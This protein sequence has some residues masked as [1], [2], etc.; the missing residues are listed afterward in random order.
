MLLDNGHGICENTNNDSNLVDARL[1]IL[2]GEL[3]I[4]AL[5]IV[6]TVDKKEFKRSAGTVAHEGAGCVNHGL[7]ESSTEVFGSL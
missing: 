1:D 5:A 7:I 4:K 2:D 6:D 3:S